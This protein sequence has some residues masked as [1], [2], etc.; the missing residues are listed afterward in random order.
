MK[1]SI[2]RAAGVLLALPLMLLTA[3][4]DSD[5]TVT[6]EQAP[7]AVTP[8]EGYVTHVS[9]NAT[10]DAG[11]TRASYDETSRKLAFTEGD[12]LYV[13]CSIN[14]VNEGS[15]YLQWKSN[16]DGV[17]TFEGDMTF[18]SPLEGTLHEFLS[19]EDCT[20]LAI[21][22]PKDY[23]SVGCIAVQEG[24][25]N[26]NKAFV[27]GSKAK[28]VEQ[29]SFEWTNTYNNGF[30]LKPETAVLAFTL[31]GLY[32]NYTYT[33]TVTDGEYS[34]S[35]TVTTDAEGVATFCTAFPAREKTYTIKIDDLKTWSLDLTPTF[36]DIS[37]GEKNLEKGHVY[38]VSRKAHIYIKRVDQSHVGK[39]LAKDALVYDTKAEA[40][41][42]AEGNAVA[43]IA[44][45]G[46]YGDYGFEHGLA[47]ALSDETNSGWDSNGTK[48]DWQTA[49][50]VCSSKA[51]L[52]AGIQ[53]SSWRLASF[54]D[55]Q[56]ML[57]C[58]TE[59]VAQNKIYSSI[60]DIDKASNTYAVLNAKLE[61]AGGDPVQAGCEYWTSTSKE[62][63]ASQ[64]SFE[65]VNIACVADFQPTTTGKVEYWTLNLDSEY[66][67]KRVRAVITF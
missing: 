45:V 23:E 18:T 12:K 28:G 66:S 38:K 59:G 65:K 55:W 67:N 62:V 31:S 53:N 37:L 20:K 51:G 26:F 58:G 7:A 46:S 40:E 57:L 9:I 6:A 19:R 44:H 48:T 36:P 41:A 32:A 25:I 34:P 22:F 30:Q 13:N 4:C 27:A 33:I 21:L 15:G 5:D 2:K 64:S 10:R 63:Y 52:T 47:I 50:S 35:G 11:T 61:A 1:I 39:I 43:M 8:S 56:Y 54:T 60:S 42:V 16:A 29:L 17:A 49:N 3:A 14:G 24:F